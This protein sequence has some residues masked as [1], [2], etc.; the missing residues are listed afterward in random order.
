MKSA[1]SPVYDTPSEPDARNTMQSPK[2]R[3]N[4]FVMKSIPLSSPFVTI[5]GEVRLSFTPRTGLM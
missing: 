1:L 2:S 3:L 5:N 4:L